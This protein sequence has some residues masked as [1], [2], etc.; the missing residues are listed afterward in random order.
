[1]T[2]GGALQAE[3]KLCAKA[4]RWGGGGCRGRAAVLPGASGKERGC[5]HIHHAAHTP[6]LPGESKQDGPDLTEAPAGQDRAGWAAHPWGQACG[7]AVLPAWLRLSPCPSR[8]AGQLICPGIWTGD[9][10]TMLEV[11]VGAEVERQEEP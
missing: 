2:E 10:E 11:V 1:M 3:G 6:S 4:P 8:P 9:R 5:G 7:L